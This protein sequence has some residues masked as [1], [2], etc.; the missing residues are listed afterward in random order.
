MSRHRDDNQNMKN[1]HTLS[2][3]EYLALVR[4][5]RYAENAYGEA[6]RKFPND[7]KLASQTATAWSKARARM[8]EAQKARLG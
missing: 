6:L 3:V 1:T 4:A 7:A 5:D 2:N 8:V